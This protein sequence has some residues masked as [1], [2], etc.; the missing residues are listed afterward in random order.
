VRNPGFT[1]VA[2]S[3]TILEILVVLVNTQSFLRPSSGIPTKHR[4]DQ[5]PSNFVVK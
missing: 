3:G 4:R 5:D 1:S 2:F